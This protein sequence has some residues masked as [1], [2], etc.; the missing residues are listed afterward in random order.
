MSGLLGKFPLRD[1]EKF[2]DEYK[3][4]NTL[5]QESLTALKHFILALNEFLDLCD[6]LTEEMV[7]NN[8]GI[9]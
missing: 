6:D 2:F 4:K 8:T 5:A 7:I 9:S 1:F 3:T